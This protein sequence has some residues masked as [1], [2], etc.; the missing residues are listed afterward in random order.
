[1]HQS[2]T[3]TSDMDRC[4]DPRTPQSL[5]LSTKLPRHPSGPTISDPNHHRA[6]S[7][8]REPERKLRPMTAPPRDSSAEKRAHKELWGMR[9]GEQQMRAQDPSELTRRMGRLKI[10]TLR[11]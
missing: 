7:L 4:T 8:P 10:S 2:C 11:V 5:W 9:N 3:H 6:A 1:M